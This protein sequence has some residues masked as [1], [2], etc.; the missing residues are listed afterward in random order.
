MC[1]GDNPATNHHA[2][3]EYRVPPFFF[4]VQDHDQDPPAHRGQDIHVVNPRARSRQVSQ[5]AHPIEAACYP[6]H[7]E[8]DVD[9]TLEAPR[10]VASLAAAGAGCVSSSVSQEGIPR[11]FRRRD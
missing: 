6:D 5:D 9:T 4:Q 7:L 1:Q 10:S 2:I 3:H 8:S 11:A